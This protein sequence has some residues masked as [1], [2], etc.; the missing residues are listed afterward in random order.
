MAPLELCTPPTPALATR[1]REQEDGAGLHRGNVFWFFFSKKNCF[2]LVFL[3]FACGAHAQIRVTEGKTAS[4]SGDD[5]VTFVADQVTY[6][7]EAQIVTASGHVEAW[8]NGHTVFADRIIFD[9]RTNVAAAEGHVVLL[10]PDGQ[11]VFSSYTEL[12]GG[13]RDAVVKGMH[14]QLAQNGRLAANG[15]RRVAAPLPADAAPGTSAEINEMSRAV[16]TTCN[17]CKEHPEAAPAW[18]IRANSAVQDPASKRIEY[19]D[20]WL[21]VYGYPIGYFPYFYTADPSVKRASGFLVPSIGNSTNIGEF[22]SIPYYWVLDDQSDVVL[23]G[24]QTTK[25]GPQLAADYRRMFNDGVLTINASLADEYH[26]A[27]GHIFA[28]GLFSFDDTYRYGFDINRATS[29]NY[30]RD[31]RIPGG[32]VPFLTTQAYVEGFGEGAYQRLDAR[33][34]QGLTQ[35]VNA[36]ALPVALPNYQYNFFGEPDALGGRF[37]LV[38]KDWS[39]TRSAGTN[40]ARL[41][42]S[43]EWERPFAGDFGDLYKITLHADAAAYDA[44]ALNQTPNFSRLTDSNYARALPQAALEVRWPLARDGGSLF[45]ADLGRQLIEPIVQLIGAPNTG[46]GSNY[47]IPNEDS[48][49]LQFTDQ[50]LFGFNRF[51]GLDRLE[52]GV[53]ANVGLH[54]ALT[55]D[56]GVTYDGL[57]GQSYREHKDDTFPIG[58][59]LNDRV[60][61]IVARAT[62]IPTNWLNFTARGRFDHDDFAPKYGELVAGVGVPL[63]SVSGGYIYDTTNPFNLYNAAPG[64]AGV[65]NIISYNP[66]TGAPMPRNEASLNVASTIGK[67]ETGQYRLSAYARRDLTTN[68]MVVAGGRATYEDECVILDLS[69]YRRYTTLNGDSGSTTVM[70]QITLK[71][72]GQFGYHAF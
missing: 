48:L 35:Q 69:A 39:I 12:T 72:V 40:D 16:Y 2:L 28:H 27:Q 43:P 11:T 65:T 64:A 41:A 51:P 45:G 1:G 49:D 32:G 36:N 18:Q 31:F 38:T 46:S 9:Q 57:V 63:L 67:T 60:S 33:A 14:A 4:A 54:T 24:T 15:A 19:E 44:N 7:R 58:S 29:Q 20:A 55:T 13:M 3:L 50:N 71:T 6:D 56:S 26:A 68:A 22:V 66:T 37:S 17:A 52:G 53:R 23:T 5:P 8:Q 10:E 61:D 59:G 62:V 30:L 42:V 21:D 47:R 34:Y 25:A 70:L